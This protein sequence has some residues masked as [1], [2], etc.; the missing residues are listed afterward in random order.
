MFVGGSIG[1]AY[2][3]VAACPIH[4]F[5]HR[6][7]PTNSLRNIGYDMSETNWV[8]MLDI[9][10]APSRGLYTALK[11]S[12]TRVSTARLPAFVVPH[13][14]MHNDSV[15]DVPETFE[16]LTDMLI[17]GDIRPFHASYAVLGLSFFALAT[18][19]LGPHA[20]QIEWPPGKIEYGLYATNY[21]RWWDESHL[22]RGGF[23]PI[24][25]KLKVPSW[26][27]LGKTK[28]MTAELELFAQVNSTILNG[29]KI[30]HKPHGEGWEPFIAIRRTGYVGRTLVESPRWHEGYVGRYH[31]KVS[32]VTEL[33]ANEADIFTLRRH[34][35]VHVP[36]RL[37]TSSMRSKMFHHMSRVYF[38]DY[39]DRLLP[40]AM[41]HPSTGAPHRTPEWTCNT[42]ANQ[43]A[44]EK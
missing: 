21:S 8:F 23:F 20:E 5:H 11:T 29:E 38:T 7:Y 22:G 4:H 43:P 44:D 19:R 14:E 2:M 1:P 35:L 39:R 3:Q 17:H 33:R 10:F 26:Y 34:F 42:S 37:T 15:K 13:F 32:F 40:I 12:V 24:N 16:D 28:N 30:R 36:H 25:T 18:H 9:D 41:S 27:R 31:N 6:Y